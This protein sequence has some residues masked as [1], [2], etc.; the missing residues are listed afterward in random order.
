M[1]SGHL[2]NAI[3]GLILGVAAGGVG[4]YLWMQPPKD[5][6]A[7]MTEVTPRAGDTHVGDLAQPFAISAPAVTRHLRVLE[8]AGLIE[9]EVNARW[10]ICRLRPGA[11]R[12]AHG[13]MEQ[14]RRY[15]EESLDRLT[16]LLEQ[17]PATTPRPR[18]SRT[19]RAIPAP[20]RRS[21]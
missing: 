4:T 19:E 18:R 16:E 2:A 20:K 5:P 15:W 17:A 3:I 21:R 13:W 9:R 14:Y 10:R 6:P 12:A 1:K 7:A 8:Q 11:M